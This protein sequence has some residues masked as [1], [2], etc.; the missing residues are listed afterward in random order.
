MRVMRERRES[1]NA[2]PRHIL[3]VDQF[4]RAYLLDLFAHANR[5]RHLPRTAQR[6]RLMT[7]ILAS[8]FYEPSTRTRLSFES[9]MAR[10]GGS[11]LSVENANESSSAT[12]G[13]SIEDT[14][15]MLQGYADAIV[16]RHP[17]P[18][19]PERASRVVDVPVINAGDGAR[20]HPTQALL[21]L[22]TIKSELGQI[23]DLDV[24]IVGDLKY[25]RAPRSLALLLCQTC[26]T[27]VTFL[28]P[29]T[30]PVGDDIK[31]ALEQHDI[32]Y[33]EATSFEEISGADVIYQTRIQ[34]ERFANQESYEQSRGYYVIDRSVM[35]L[36]KPE[37]IVLHPLPRVDEISPEVDSD[38]RAA[39]LVWC[40]GRAISWAGLRHA[41]ETPHPCKR[42]LRAALCWLD[43][44]GPRRPLRAHGQT[45]RPGAG[46]RA[47]AR[48]RVRGRSG[49][50]AR[51][52]PGRP[53]W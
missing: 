13:E 30:V 27:R 37:A 16:M 44:S 46:S 47:G 22:Y 48:L 35:E 20:E 5:L 21:D 32:S 28:A 6:S 53:R 3:S 10:L 17:E 36:L 41:P 38:P 12:K 1:T 49:A 52:S 9:A 4:D 11:V 7:S 8:V 14:A 19:M 51:T 29:P 43:R 31:H 23:D 39:W 18:G 45:T 24:A 25:G 50:V 40:D 42:W 33:R 15:R 2:M 26:G 34:R